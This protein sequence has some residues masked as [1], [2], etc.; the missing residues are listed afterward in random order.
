M[1]WLITLL[2]LSALVAPLAIYVWTF[3][4]ELSR[5]HPRWAEMGSAMSGIYTPILALL[6]L[7]VLAAQVRLQA[8]MNR[9]T[10][11]QAY[12][13]EARDQISFALQQLAVEIV[14]K[15]PDGTE[16]RTL[17]IGAFAY[18]E[19]AALQQPKLQTLAQA[20]HNQHNP[21]LFALWSEFYAAL[22]GLR[23]HEFH[24][25]S[26]AFSAMKQRAITTLSYEGCA[27]L[28][29]FV[30]CMSEGRLNYGFEFSRAGLPPR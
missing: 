23:T 10:F 15:T 3:G 18:Q 14:K 24:P 2:I 28:D 16:V 9:H 7:A 13:Q 8:S 19:M 27:A 11:D 25:Y 12:V 29:N 21:R 30:W 6:T 4:P 5:E 26:S 1:A 17:L 22:A 20:V